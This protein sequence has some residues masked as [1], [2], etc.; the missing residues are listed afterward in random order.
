MSVGDCDPIKVWAAGGEER[1]PPLPGPQSLPNSRGLWPGVSMVSPSCNLLKLFLSVIC[2]SPCKKAGSPADRRMK[3]V[4]W[5]RRCACSWTPG[6]HCRSLMEQLRRGNSRSM[7]RLREIPVL[8]Q[9][10]ACPLHKEWTAGAVTPVGEWGKKK[11]QDI[12]RTG[13]NSLS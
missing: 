7:G 11:Q 13:T 4:W 5:N 1:L 8:G 6:G 2:P 9:V 12:P 3:V 10:S